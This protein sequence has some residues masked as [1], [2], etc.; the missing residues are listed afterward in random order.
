MMTL[1]SGVRVR[2]RGGSESHFVILIGASM[3]CAMHFAIHRYKHA[4]DGQ[5]IDRV[6]DEIMIVSRQ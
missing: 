3:T 1:E 5:F 4:T 6:M 2:N